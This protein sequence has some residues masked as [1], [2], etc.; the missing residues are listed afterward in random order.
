VADWPSWANDLLAVGLLVFSTA[1]FLVLAALLGGRSSRVAGR[2]TDTTRRDR[3][4]D[5]LSRRS[6]LF[7]PTV[8]ALVL[9]AVPT[10]YT[11]FPE[12]GAD[13]RTGWR[14]S[15]LAGWIV[16]AGMGALLTTAT[17][18]RLHAMVAEE[19]LEQVRAARRSQ[20]SDQ[21]RVIL[22]PGVADIPPQ[23][24]FTV[25]V[26]TPNNAFLIPVFPPA[27]DYTDP[28]IFPVGAGATGKAWQSPDGSFVV[29]G[30]AVSGPEHGLSKA[31]S[32]R[33]GS[34]QAAAATV[35]Y[36]EDRRPV[37]VLT[38]IGR[39]DDHF[40]TDAEGRGVAALRTVAGGVAWLMPS[41]VAWMLP[42]PVKV[43]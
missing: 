32:T 7:V 38:A 36:A 17:D 30:D 43:D 35:I 2:S 23:Y 10:A 18:R 5:W 27:L 29:V 9:V 21:F 42:S 31:Q 1:G 40:F 11:I 37:G 41:A 15:I 34:Y 14:V 8:F 6:R 33:Y 39:V 3:L 16:L 24:Q 25:Y 4:F 26:P 22:V 20:I 19:R 13:A 28:A 12:W